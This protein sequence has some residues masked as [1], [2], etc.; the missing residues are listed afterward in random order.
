MAS[1]KLTK[2]YQLVDYAMREK[3][4]YKKNDDEFMLLI[5]VKLKKF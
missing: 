1:I 4:I 3:I 2:N 5:Y